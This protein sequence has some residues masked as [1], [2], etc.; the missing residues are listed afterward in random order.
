M[1]K[2]IGLLAIIAFIHTH[3]NG[4]NLQHGYIVKSNHEKIS[5]YLEE[6]TDDELRKQLVF[7]TGLKDEK[8]IYNANELESFVFDYGRTFQSF[9]LKIWDGKDSVETPV[10]AKR[11]WMGKIEM[12]TVQYENNLVY[13]L[14][15]QLTNEWVLL[16]RPMDETRIEKGITI[17]YQGI[18]YVQYNEYE[19]SEN[20][21]KAIN[22]SLIGL[23]L[24]ADPML[25]CPFFNPSFGLTYKHFP[26]YESSISRTSYGASGESL[27]FSVQAAAGAKCR[28]SPCFCVLGLCSFENSVFC[29]NGG[30]AYL[31]SK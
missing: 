10:F 14:K 31:Y 25:V 29:L 7:S 9:L 15:N 5:G 12:Y 1:K 22:F 18:S 21:V 23:K 4:Q 30:V 27:R 3:T 17:V 20:K 2:L 24:Q 16:K 11:I 19:K 28:L 26:I 13:I 8:I 6:H